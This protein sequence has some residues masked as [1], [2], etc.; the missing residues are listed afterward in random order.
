MGYGEDVGG[1]CDTT[2][3]KVRSALELSAE[4]LPSICIEGGTKGG[5][6]V[7]WVEADLSIDGVFLLW[8]MSGSK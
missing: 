1:A 7:S 5:G 3:E 6:Q 2:E 8:P 4:G